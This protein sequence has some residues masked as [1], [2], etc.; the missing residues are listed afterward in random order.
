MSRVKIALASGLAA[1]AAGLALTL[2]Q[3]PPSVARANGAAADEGLVARALESA[4]FCQGGELL[5]AGT[6]AVRA[7]LSTFTGPR[8]EVTI[9]AAG[10]RV[11]SGERPSG[12]TSKVVTVPVKP[13]AHAVH[14]AN[15]CFSF[16]MSDE[17]LTAYG[18]LTPPAIS[19]RYES[20]PLAGRIT[21]E[22]LRSGSH[23]WA[24]LAG[25]IARN[26]GFGRATPGSWVVFALLAMT[27]AIVALTSRTV[28]KAMP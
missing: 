28:L 18:R 24:S 26:L 8:V 3:A 6:T 14:G 17:M 25:D 10:R 12:W 1:I 2:M 4:T 7:A 22:Y 15:V 13:L 5:P 16:Q 19:G 9:S 21:I 11:T 23:S 27:V 20:E